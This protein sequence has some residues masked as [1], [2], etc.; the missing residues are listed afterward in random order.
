[1]PMRR[2]VLCLRA[3]WG[4][5]K[6]WVLGGKRESEDSKHDVYWFKQ[7]ARSAVDFSGVNSLQGRQLYMELIASKLSANG[8]KRP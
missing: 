3:V 4:T 1:M 6:S 2:H 5:Q 8:P 7:T